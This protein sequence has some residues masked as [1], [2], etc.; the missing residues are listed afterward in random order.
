MTEHFFQTHNN[1]NNLL[2]ANFQILLFPNFHKHIRYKRSTGI[3][4]T[5]DG[6]SNPY[7]SKFAKTSIHKILIIQNSSPNLLVGKLIV[8]KV[9]AHA[10]ANY[11]NV[12]FTVAHAHAH[13]NR[14]SNDEDHRGRVI[15]CISKRNAARRRR[16]AVYLRALY[17]NCAN[18]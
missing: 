6:F 17:I 13:W 12:N 3:S 4:N 8:K 10:I 5:I 9:I 16:V 18:K 11:V 1:Y 14:L 2:P 7:I 15:I